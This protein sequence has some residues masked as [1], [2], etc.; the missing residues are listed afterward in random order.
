MSQ[1][2][3]IK[4]DPRSKSTAAELKKQHSFL[5]EIRDQLSKCHE[6]I[7]KSYSVKKHIGEWI[8]KFTKS[9]VQSI[10]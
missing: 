1:E 9:Q 4:I 7:Q 3:E 2:F 8:N 5:M 10:I 6:T